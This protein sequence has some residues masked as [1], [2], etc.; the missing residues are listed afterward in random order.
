M[1]ILFICRDKKGFN[2]PLPEI[3]MFEDIETIIVFMQVKIDL[4]GLKRF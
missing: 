1:S 3:V 4:C 2:N